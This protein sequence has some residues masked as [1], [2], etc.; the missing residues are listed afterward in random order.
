LAKN[1]RGALLADH[2]KILN[3]WKNYFCELLNGNGVGGVRQ[4]EIHTAVPFVPEP[5]ASE[6]EVAIGNL[7]RY[8]SVGVDQI[9]AELIQAGGKILGSE[10]HNLIKLVWNKEELPHQSKE[11]IVVP[12][13]KKGD[14]TDCS[15]Y[16]GISLLSNS[17]KTLSNILFSRLTPTANAIIGDHQC[18]TKSW[19][20]CI[21]VFLT[22]PIPYTFNS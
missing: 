2:H 12:I 4:T 17:Y 14:K 16:R 8:K 15:N 11:S 21:S 10:T 9:P 5:S 13:H 19:A 18:D 1:K 7:K 3:R 20:V 6:A 22:P